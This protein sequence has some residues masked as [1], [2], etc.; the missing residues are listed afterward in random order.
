MRRVGKEIEPA[1]R[2]EPVAAVE[3][4]SRVARHRRRIARHV[5]EPRA[6]I[7]TSDVIASA[8][9][10]VRGGSTMTAAGTRGERR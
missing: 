10:P 4:P 8:E 6:P 5:D 2:L 3:Q 7:F 1:Q 9:M